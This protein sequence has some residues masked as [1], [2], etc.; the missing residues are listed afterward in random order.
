MSTTTT[1][2]TSETNAPVETA[3]KKASRVDEPTDAKVHTHL[4]LN[5]LVM[6]ENIRNETPDIDGL[7]QTI[8]EVGVLQPIGVRVHRDAEGDVVPNKYDVVFGFRRTLAAKAAHLKEVPVFFVDAD[9]ARRHMLAMIENLQRADMN[10][11]EKAQGIQKMIE[12]GLNQKEVAQRLGMTEGF[13]SQ[14]LSLLKLPPKVKTA[15]TNGKIELSQARELNRLHDHEEKMLEFL[16]EVPKMSTVE[17]KTKIDLFLEKEKAKAEKAA[18]KSSKKRASSSDDDDEEAPSSTRKGKKSL[19]DQYEEAEVSPLTKTNL[20]EK[21]KAY[22]LKYENAKSA[23]K[24]REY[25]LILK[26]IEI[27]AGLAE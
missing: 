25:K 8:K 23:E 10:P 9:D 11:M 27:G 5:Q 7:A 3:G 22:A 2:T 16:P 26:G 13:V 21:L 15:V 1:E 18:S 12:G 24:Q 6:G 19:V 20:R 4:P 14:H 17:L